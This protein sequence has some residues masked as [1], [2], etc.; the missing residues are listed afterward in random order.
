MSPAIFFCRNSLQKNSIYIF[1]DERY[2]QRTIVLLGK[3]ANNLIVELRI[4]HHLTN[5]SRYVQRSSVKT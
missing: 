5:P 2:I 4:D 3:M 1:K